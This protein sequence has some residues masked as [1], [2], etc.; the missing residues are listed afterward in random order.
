MPASAQNFDD[1]RMQR[2][3]ETRFE[4]VRENDKNAQAT[5][6]LA[7]CVDSELDQRGQPL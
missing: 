1:A 3:N 6:R 2:R 7:P 5:L 4:R